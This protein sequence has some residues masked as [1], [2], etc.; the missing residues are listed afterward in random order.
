MLLVDSSQ[1]N[2]LFSLDISSLRVHMVV[3]V[4]LNVSLNNRKN[5]K[6]VKLIIVKRKYS[7]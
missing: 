5:A 4:V 3:K 7:F 6:N 2:T 1:M